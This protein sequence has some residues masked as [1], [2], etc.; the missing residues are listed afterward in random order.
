MT[1]IRS[2]FE[3]GFTGLAI[4][5]ISFLLFSLL[6]Y[7][8]TK[9]F[10]SLIVINVF[11]FSVKYFFYNIIFNNSK[12]DRKFNKRTFIQYILFYIV[13]YF[14][15][16]IILESFVSVFDYN[17]YI[18]QLLYIV[19]FGVLSYFLTRYIFINTN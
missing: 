3:F 8:G 5:I 6:I 14:A 4:E 13:A 1:D 15:N 18:T 19:L 10:I 7:F 17:I 12:N 2:I 9:I 16:L 11:G